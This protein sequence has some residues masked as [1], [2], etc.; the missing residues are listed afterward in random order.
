[1]PEQEETIKEV[2]VNQSIVGT[3]QDRTNLEE[4]YKKWK[5]TKS[6]DAFANLMQKIHDINDQEEKNNI[7]KCLKYVKD[8]EYWSGDY[9]DEADYEGY[10]EDYGEWYRDYKKKKMERET[11]IQ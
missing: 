1:M 2:N 11:Y 3:E 6:N 5:Q 4:L 9:E 8:Y 7:L 10:E